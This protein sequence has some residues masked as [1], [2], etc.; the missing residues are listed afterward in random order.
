MVA[1]GGVKRLPKD[2]LGDDGGTE[3]MFER[4]RAA[5]TGSQLRVVIAVQASSI[6]R[7][8]AVGRV[9]AVPKEREEIFVGDLRRVEV[10]L[11]RLRVVA[12]VA[13]RVALAL[14]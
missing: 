3:I 7:A 5:T 2:D 11:N 4:T 13:G 9:V 8:L 10:E 1:L 14:S 12:D 6:L